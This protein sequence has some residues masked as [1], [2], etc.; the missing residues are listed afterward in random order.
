MRVKICLWSSSGTEDSSEY[1]RKT[2]RNTDTDDCN[3]ANVHGTKTLVAVVMNDT[4]SD[5]T[6]EGLVDS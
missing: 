5:S 2:K 1:T 3:D 4:D 6:A